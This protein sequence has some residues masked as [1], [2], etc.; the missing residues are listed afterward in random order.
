LFPLYHLAIDCVE[1]AVDVA[2]YVIHVALC[3]KFV[4]HGNRS[5]TSVCLERDRDVFVC[6]RFRLGRVVLP[7]SSYPVENLQLP[8][9][10]PFIPTQHQ[11]RGVIFVYSIPVVVVGVPRQI[12]EIVVGCPRGS[13]VVR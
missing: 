7:I 13:V 9:I 3:R 12:P 6:A 2:D 11:L 5:R 8:L 4:R 10:A 1:R